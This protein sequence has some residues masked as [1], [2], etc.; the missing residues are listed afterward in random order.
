M[1]DDALAAVAETFSAA[2][3][4][5]TAAL[6]ALSHAMES[7]MAAMMLTHQPTD[8]EVTALIAELWMREAGLRSCLAF[9]EVPDA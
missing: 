2:V 9:L 6:H 5:V 7:R 1:P 3:R 8:E 4:D